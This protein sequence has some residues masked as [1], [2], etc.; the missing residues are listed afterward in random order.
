M[1]TD[2]LLLLAG[3]LAVI[4]IILLLRQQGRQAPTQGGMVSRD[5]LEALQGQMEAL[6]GELS[7]REDELRKTLAQL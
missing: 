4:L 1:D 6:K 2:F 5:L 3:F 7:I